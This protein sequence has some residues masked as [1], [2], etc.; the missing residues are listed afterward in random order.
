MGAPALDLGSSMNEQAHTI[1]QVVGRY[2][3]LDVIAAGGMATVHFGRLL[4]PVGFSRTVAIKRLHPEFARDPEFVSM[5]VDEA[6]LAARIRHRNVVPTLD[7]IA[8][9]G[10]LFLVMEYVLGESL[11]ALLRRLRRQG[12]P[13]I[14]PAVAA[15]ILGGCLEGLHAAHETCDEQGSNL[16]IV[17]RDVSPTNV[18]VGA[19]GMA[20][21]LD[22][23]IAKAAGRTYTTREGEVKGKVAYM[24]PE[25]LNS[26][27]VTRQADVYAAAVVLWESLTGKRAF[28]GDNEAIVVS[29]AMFGELSRPSTVDPELA[30]YDEVVMRGL[31]RAPDERYQTARQMAIEL[32]QAPTAT[33]SQV[34]DWL[35][36]VVGSELQKRERLLSSIEAAPNATEVR[37]ALK[38]ELALDDPSIALSISEV[39]L[40]RHSERDVTPT[41]R[42]RASKDLMT[43]LPVPESPAL[44]NSRPEAGSSEATSVPVSM[45]TLARF[46]VP[47]QPPE[48]SRGWMVGIGALAA[49]MVGGLGGYLYISTNRSAANDA[50]RGASSGTVID[51]TEP[52][53]GEGRGEV[54]QPVDVEDPAPPPSVT[55]DLDEPETRPPSQRRHL[56]KPAAS[57]SASAKPKASAKPRSGSSDPFDELGGRH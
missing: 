12:N 42:E 41:I 1:A 30:P 14:P 37:A 47:Q 53:L 5:F 29:R 33:L 20:R 28:A 35:E 48:R 25:Q 13:R 56:R 43:P 23:G 49:L 26:G 15:S 44:P 24:A 51:A 31:S 6:R 10:E 45:D 3:L 11:G 16:G 19:D 32:E 9:D 18:L 40:P 39:S 17:H 55:I 54:E 36:S 34:A 57:A 27:E 22:F 38:E 2:M 52:Q 50:A 46:K 4:G 21:V 7:V 8:D